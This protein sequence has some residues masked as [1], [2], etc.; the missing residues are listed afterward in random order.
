MCHSESWKSTLPLRVLR[1]V[2]CVTETS[3]IPYAA[4]IYKLSWLV[5]QKSSKLILSQWTTRGAESVLFNKDNVWV[6]LKYLTE[7]TSTVQKASD[8]MLPVGDSPEKTIILAKWLPGTGW[9]EM[10]NWQER[11]SS[12]G[13]TVLQGLTVKFGLYCEI[14]SVLWNLACTIMTTWNL[15][16]SY[17]KNSGVKKIWRTIKYLDSRKPRL[18]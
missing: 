16:Y 14:W 1:D 11:Y 4:S 13:K 8:Y 15:N 3:V 9:D 17:M 2:V 6:W 5:L 18:I 10:E 7:T 12:G